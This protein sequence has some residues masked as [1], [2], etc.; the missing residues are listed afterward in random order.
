MVVGQLV[1]ALLDSAAAIAVMTGPLG[2]PRPAPPGPEGA[3]ISVLTP[4]GIHVGAGTA[5]NLAAD[6]WAGPVIEAAGELMA[7]LVERASRAGPP[8]G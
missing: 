8:R 2:G 5:R 4:G 3:M 6:P 1:R 7:L